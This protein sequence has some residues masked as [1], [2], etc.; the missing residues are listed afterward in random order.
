MH[1]YSIHLNRAYLL[2]GINT[3]LPYFDTETWKA[4]IKLLEN[5]INTEHI[6]N[7]ELK[8]INSSLA[9][10]TSGALW[11]LRQLNKFY[12]EKHFL[13]FSEKQISIL[14]KSLLL[15]DVFKTEY[16][17]KTIPG[18][19]NGYAGAL[20]ALLSFDLSKEEEVTCS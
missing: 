1:L 9:T 3:F 13:D 2:F 17:S 19:L 16:T 20:I 7:K 11:I 10:G 15:E 12:P 5:N 6:V 8:S 14:K 18:L 4:H